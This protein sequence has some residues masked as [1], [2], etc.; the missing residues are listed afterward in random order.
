MTEW[1]L[2]RA[3]CREKMNGSE[4]WDRVNRC[5]RKLD[6]NKWNA[7][8]VISIFTRGYLTPDD[9]VGLLQT[10]HGPPIWYQLRRVFQKFPPKY[11]IARGAFFAIPHD[12]LLLALVYSAGAEF[13]CDFGHVHTLTCKLPMHC[14]AAD[15][16]TA[17]LRLQAFERVQWHIRCSALL[18]GMKHFRKSPV[19]SKL[20]RHVVSMIAKDIWNLQFQRR[21]TLAQHKEFVSWWDDAIFMVA[22]IVCICILYIW[23]QL[24]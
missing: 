4:G 5:L 6:R 21:E 15:F 10:R 16:A 2:Q 24:I 12:P 11:S 8:D 13:R 17:Y 14:R 23:S 19:L 20:D 9:I 1:G 7:Y 18:R 3:G 22:A